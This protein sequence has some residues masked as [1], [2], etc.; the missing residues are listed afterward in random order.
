MGQELFWSGA[1][2]C[3]DYSHTA[4]L[5]ALVFISSGQRHMGG[6]SAGKKC[7]KGHAMH[8][9]LLRQGICIYLGK[10]LP[11]AAG[12]EREGP[13]RMQERGT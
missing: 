4:R 11:R 1:D 6:R 2:P 3:Q 12:L 7:G 13:Q 8:I 5:V 9:G 10:L